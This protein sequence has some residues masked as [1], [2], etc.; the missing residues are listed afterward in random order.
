MSSFFLPTYEEC[1]QIVAANEAFYV[2]YVEVEGQQVAMFN[3]RLAQLKDFAEPVPSLPLKAYE[4]RGLTFVE[5]NGQWRRYLMLHKFFNVNQ[6]EGYQLN[7]LSQHQ[8][9]RVQDKADGSMIRFIKINGHVRAKTKNSFDNDQALM[10]QKVLDLQ[11]QLRAFV[12]ATLAEGLVAI[13]ELVSAY[14]QIVVSYKKTE[15]QLLQLREE[16]SGEYLDIYSHPLVLQNQ[17]L[18]AVSEPVCPLPDLLERA[19]TVENREGWVVTLNNGQMAKIKGQ[20]YL[21]RHGLLTFEL[22]RE[23]TIMRLILEEKIDDAFSMLNEQ[24][25]RKDYADHIQQALVHYLKLQTEAVLSLV[26]QY[27]GVRK[28]FALAHKANPLFSVAIRLI[29]DPVD[30]EEKAYKYLVQKTL[31][32][33]ATLMEAKKFVREKLGVKLQHLEEN[34]SDE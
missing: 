29:E 34:Y 11:P 27:T 5:E 1:L 15:L 13:F 18:C 3:Y 7:E 6:V 22:A 8:V 2:K 30:Q 12:E 23:N 28:D 14:N 10:A 33:T 9:V 26:Q 32:D 24:D 21:D 20:W 19:K 4:L 31:R 17:T 25:A 16:L